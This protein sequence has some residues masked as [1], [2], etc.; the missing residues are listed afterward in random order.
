MRKIFPN[1]KNETKPSGDSWKAVY[2]IVTKSL[3]QAIYFY[4]F[5][6]IDWIEWHPVFHNYDFVTF[7][8][9]LKLGIC[10]DIH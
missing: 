8:A 4:T 5:H 9:E 6:T 3:D 2:S 7:T 10:H 1:N